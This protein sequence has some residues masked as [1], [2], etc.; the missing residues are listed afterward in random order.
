M[1]LCIKLQVNCDKR[2]ERMPPGKIMTSN[3]FLSPLH[4]ERQVRGH[5][6]LHKI[7]GAARCRDSGEGD[8]PAALLAT[9]E[10]DEAGGGGGWDA[11]R[12]HVSARGR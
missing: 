12:R 7:N 5:Q 8:Q 1:S 11:S 2:N 9:L 6:L 4:K 3:D 10:K